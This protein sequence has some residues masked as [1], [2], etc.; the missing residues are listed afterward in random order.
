MVQ[1]GLGKAIVDAINKS[2]G[3]SAVTYDIENGDDV[4]DPQ[5]SDWIY[6]EKFDALINCAG[7]NRNEWFS[8]ISRDGAQYVMDVN[9]FSM[10][11]MTQALLKGIVEAKGFVL[12]IVS[13][14]AHIPMTSSLAYN[15]SKAAALMITKQMAH[16]L[17]PKF[18]IACSP[19]ARTSCVAPAC[20]S[21]LKITSVRR[22]AGHRNFAA[23]YQ[24]KALMHGLETEP[25]AIADYIVHLLDT[26]NWKFM[27]G[28]DIPFGK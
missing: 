24:K 8:D 28:T 25:Q 15:A 1:S 13:N 2:K 9:A 20:L 4:T 21:R 11:Y 19:S 7:I 10:V 23:E 26:G 16:E 6:H 3:H 14:A 12:N 27:S 5:G 18:G 22:A 17:T